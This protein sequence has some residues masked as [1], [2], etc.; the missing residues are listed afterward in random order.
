MAILNW[1]LGDLTIKTCG[2]KLGF[3]FSNSLLN[4]STSSVGVA[5]TGACS[6]RSFLKGIASPT[7]WCKGLYFTSAALSGVSCATSSLCLLSGYS[8]IGPLP[9]LTGTLAYCTSVGARGCNALA[10]CMDPAAGLTAKGVD[11]CIDLAT[12]N[13]S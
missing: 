2:E 12:K 11:T 1:L 6:A 8:C 13:W 3:L 7:L 10:D 9:I 5:F 4:A